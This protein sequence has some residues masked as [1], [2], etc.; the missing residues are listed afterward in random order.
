MNPEASA[1]DLKCVNLTA[2]LSAGADMTVIRKAY[3]G[4]RI[5]KAGGGPSQGCGV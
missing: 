5:H 2:D 1:E 4:G 3:E